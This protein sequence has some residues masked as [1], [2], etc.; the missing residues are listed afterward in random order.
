MTLHLPGAGGCCWCV[1]CGK[2]KRCLL[3]E[4][5][6][7]KWLLDASVLLAGCVVVGV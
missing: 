7:R 5:E 6:Q 3:E 2:R 1:R 4:E